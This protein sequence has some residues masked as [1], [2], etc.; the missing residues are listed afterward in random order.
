MFAPDQEPKCSDAVTDRSSYQLQCS[1]VVVKLEARER[2]N[3]YRCGLTS[4][5]AVSRAAASHLE[6]PSSCYTIVAVIYTITPTMA[7]TRTLAL[8]LMEVRPFLPPPHPL[9]YPLLAPATR[10]YLPTILLPPPSPPT[11]LTSLH[12]RRNAQSSTQPTTPPPCAPATASSANAFA[13]P[14]WQPTTPAA[15][16]SSQTC[17]KH[18]L[19]LRPTMTL[20]RIALRVLLLRSREE[21]VR[22]RR[23]GRLLVSGD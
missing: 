2:E 1:F 14:Q 21:R 3:I 5:S 13:A 11:P 4:A 15:S 23:R 10:F 18:I 19:A 12:N 6:H 8:K 7:V 16:P 20:R 9:P 17:K 22:L